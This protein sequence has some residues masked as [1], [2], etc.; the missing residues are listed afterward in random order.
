MNFGNAIVALVA[1]PRLILLIVA[2]LALAGV[3]SFGRMSR[4]EDPVFPDE[5]G[6]ITVV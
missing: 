6:L 4:Q 1:R 5:N 3:G 2:M